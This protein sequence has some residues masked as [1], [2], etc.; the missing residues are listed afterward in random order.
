MPRMT[1]RS[2]SRALSSPLAA[3]MLASL[4]E[5]PWQSQAEAAEYVRLNRYPRMVHNFLLKEVEKSIARNRSLKKKISTKDEARKY[6]ESVRAKIRKSFGPEPE[7]TPLN[8]RVTGVVERDGYR[9]EKVIFESRPGFPVTANLYLPGRIA[10]KLPGI[11]GTCGH[12]LNGK[13][14]EAYQSFSQGLAKLG[15][16]CLIYDPI[17]QGERSQYVDEKLKSTVRMG[18]GQHLHGGNQQY[19]VG[20]FFGAWRAWDGVR[21]LDYLLSRDEIDEQRVGVTGN[22]GGGTMT[23]WLCGVERRWK[24]AAPSCFVTS[25][26]NNFQ[27]ELPADTEQC[28]PKALALG[29]D[30][31]DFLAAMAP[32]PVIILA[33]ERDYF[34]VRG[35]EGA[36]GRLRDLYKK[37]GVEENAGLFVGP[38]EHGFSEENRLAMYQWFAQSSGFGEVVK[39][40]GLTIE[41]D[42]TLW[43]TP[44][45]H[46]AELD[47]AKSIFD[48]TK[49]H[50]QRLREARKPVSSRQ[51]RRVVRAVLKFPKKKASVPEYQIYRYL[52]SRGYPS[53][54]AVAYS[55]NTEPGVSA[56]VYR[57]TE[58]RWQSRPPQAGAKAILYVSHLSSDAE[59]RE[60]PLIKELIEENQGVPFFTCDV[61]GIG[62]SLP[63]TGSPNSF[64]SAY[65][66]DYFYAAHSLMLDRPYLGQ[67]LY[68]VI[69][70]LEWLESLGHTEV[71]LVGNGFGALPATFAALFA[72]NV[73][74]VT[75]KNALTSY[76]DV[77]ETEHYELPLSAMLP[78]VLKHFDLPDCYRELESKN[79]RQIE[80]NQPHAEHE[81]DTH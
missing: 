53:K 62:E 79:L 50:S 8:A 20:E 60:E 28:P 56:I 46:V 61:R 43:C 7:K 66:N 45:G 38:T 48:F 72:E 75:L 67:K 80:P 77:A 59:L 55:V 17:G 39:E 74:R 15:F 27:N 19:L 54:S 4:G 24:M 2:F 70:V 1:R 32:H 23:T 41:E 6:V 44:N 14:A 10:G 49:E 13:A 5:F 78:D 34:D 68:D 69:R 33:K 52:G 81:A 12:S 47:G 22:S 36:Y 64:H 40:P 9:I 3:S 51:L 30:H 76:S 16:A 25:F 63:G 73:K 37:L 58:G 57:L 65:G 35:A 71:H 26:L 31:E 18:T 21:A 29:L 42:E 11:I